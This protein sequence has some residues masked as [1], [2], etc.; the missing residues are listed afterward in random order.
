MAKDIQVTTNFTAGELSPRVALGRPDVAK[1]P[2]GSRRLEN[3]VLAVQGGAMRRPGSRYI[4]TT[5]NNGRARLIDFVFSRDQSYIVEMGAGYLR[6]LRN[7]A[8][9]LASGNPF[10]I[11]SPYTLAQLR[12]V[13]YAQKSDTAFLVNPEVAPQRLQ[14]FADNNWFLAPTPFSTQPATEQGSKPAVGVTLGSAG[15]GAT[16]ATASSAYW[17]T[18][19]IGRTIAY[20]AGSATIT[21]LSSSTVA[22]VTVDSAFPSTALA[23]GSW[24]LTG[25]PAA[26]LRP[27]AKD[28]VSA[29][30]VLTLAPPVN[31]TLGLAQKTVGSGINATAGS[32]TFV[33]G[34]V[35][36]VIYA[37]SGL[38][39]ITAYTSATSVTVDIREPFLSTTYAAKGWGMNGPNEWRAEDVGKLV[40]VNGGIYRIEAV[41][42][43]A[44][45]TILVPATSTI[46][47]PPFGWR[48]LSKAWSGTGG[49]PQAVALN[50]QRLLLASTA[51]FPQT[52]W[53][54][55]IGDT[56][57]FTTST[58]DADGF[59]FELDGARNSPIQHLVASRRL[60]ALTDLD[61]MSVSGSEAARSSITPTSIQKTDE[62]SA[63]SNFVRP[64]KIGN[65]VLFVQAAGKKVHAIGYR[66]DIDGFSSPDRTVFAEHI[67]GNGI[68]E[69]AHQKLPDSTLMCVR[70]DGQMA[71]CAYDVEQEVVGWGRWITQGQ[72]ESVANIPTS[73]K[74]DA[75]TTVRRVINGEERRFIEVFDS[76]VLLDCAVV[77]TS[78]TP[79]TVWGGLEHLEG[80][81]VQCLAD[82]AYM[83]EFTVEGGQITL[84]RP[85]T[86]TQI[87]LG[88]TCLVEMLPPPQVQGTQVHVNEVILRVLNTGALYVNGQA[89][90]FKRRFGPDLLDLPPG[91]FTGDVRET[92]L[93]DSI[94]QTEQVITQPLPAPFHLLD[95]IRKMT[96]NQ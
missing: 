64:Q 76:E 51:A 38:A 61:E 75:Y 3:I 26:F 20:L 31:A 12:A 81:T 83:D 32:A 63:G 72:Y 60:L 49:Y 16:T 70:E 87:G 35:G 58:A 30:A 82:G 8:Q 88:F 21:S 23:S 10:E 28:P 25:S 78:P 93:S 96:I 90:E 77:A 85:A 39:V 4:A 89:I 7:R 41:G 66:Y 27:D 91:T 54:S 59:A 14:R 80:A 62:S 48:L 86:S 52:L 69:M 29:R 9:I 79:T 45:T 33:P 46:A 74:E 50:N 43:S 44:V 95:V 22:N 47:A 37:D 67:T 5:K 56:L 36:R 92:T 6:F 84:P 18:S 19:D 11:T 2:N 40:E 17:V 71:V 57:D 73:T 53:G 65:E 1:Y 34:D 24:T 55:V 42:G 68:V 15:V 13:R 94:Y